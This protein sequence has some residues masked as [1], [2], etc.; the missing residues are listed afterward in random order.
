MVQEL[1]AFLPVIHISLYKFRVFI[2]SLAFIYTIIEICVLHHQR[3][4]IVPVVKNRL[5]LT[6][7]TEEE[8][9][10]C[11]LFTLLGTLA[12]FTGIY[13]KKKANTC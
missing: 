2:F 9:V 11:T 5:Y 13:R 3:K 1:L 6:P 7:V 4:F 10:L 12:L 8:S